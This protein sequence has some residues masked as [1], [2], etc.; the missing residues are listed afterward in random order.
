MHQSLKFCFCPHR[1][2]DVYVGQASNAYRFLCFCPHRGRDV[3]GKADINELR[4]KGFCPHRGRDVY[5]TKDAGKP[6]HV[7]SVPIGGAM[8]MHLLP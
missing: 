2:R 5:V 3:Y 8:F 7:V 6:F 4:E 1:G